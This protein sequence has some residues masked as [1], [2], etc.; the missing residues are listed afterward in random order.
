LK[1]EGRKTSFKIS[2]DEIMLPSRM[3]RCP[4]QEQL[5]R[6]KIKCYCSLC[7]NV[8][9][10]LKTSNTVQK[11]LAYKNMGTI[12][13]FNRSGIYQLKCQNCGKKFTGHI[14]RSFSKR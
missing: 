13:K 6:A 9:T 5:I 14:G 1:Q 12:D 10:A 8:K 2:A 7:N 11:I 3:T 4:A